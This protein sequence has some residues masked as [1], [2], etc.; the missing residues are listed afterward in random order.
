MLECR[1]ELR[2]FHHCRVP[3]LWGSR[4]V[5]QVRV[6]YWS[7]AQRSS[8]HR[9]RIWRC[10][11]RKQKRL[12]SSAVARSAGPLVTRLPCGK[13]QWNST[14][15]HWPEGGHGRRWWIWA[16]ACTFH[17]SWIALAAGHCGG[18]SCEFGPVPEVGCFGL[19]NN[20]MNKRFVNEKK[21]EKIKMKIK[22]R[23]PASKRT[24]RWDPR[25]R[26]GRRW[27]VE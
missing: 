16:Q 21:I 26:G 14:D 17:W 7:T 22:R 9:A 20:E 27:L 19:R 4:Q 13:R 25:R 10:C 1:T 6:P 11:W 2:S 3:K 12:P 15:F 5:R 24:R 18:H 8:N 23:A